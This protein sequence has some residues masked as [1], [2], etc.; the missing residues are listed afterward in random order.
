[1]VSPH[2]LAAHSSRAEPVSPYVV[3]KNIDGVSFDFMIGDRVGEEWYKELDTLTP[4]MTFMR[5]QMVRAG[6]S[7]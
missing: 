3:K 7:S 4:E 2:D 5:N 1:M 6:T